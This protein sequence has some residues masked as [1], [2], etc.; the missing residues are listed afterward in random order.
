MQ[1]HGK[2]DPKRGSIV[3]RQAQ[4]SSALG[5]VSNEQLRN[6]SSM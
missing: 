2:T 1:Q 4:P 5:F 3:S 6:R